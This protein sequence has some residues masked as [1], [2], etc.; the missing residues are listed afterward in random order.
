MKR[1]FI[2]PPALGPEA[3]AEL[4][5]WLALTGNREDALLE[6]LLGAALEL[7]E[8][9]TGQLPLE[10]TCE[11]TLPAAACWQA[12]AT[13]PVQAIVSLSGI[14]AE[15]PRFAL[16]ADA[17]ALELDADAGAR[18]RVS[19]PGSAGRIAVRFIAGLAPR[20]SDLPESLRHGIV[21]LAAHQH[22]TREGAAAEPVPP[23]AVAALWR[24]WR[25]MRVA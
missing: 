22:R 20:W 10:A 4:K 18:V 25:R 5:Q 17:Y 13:R 21:R 8:G 15:G 14:P 11:E 23:A 24:P 6:T 7:C 9:F 2:V 12:L 16:A 1:A 3:L 19:R